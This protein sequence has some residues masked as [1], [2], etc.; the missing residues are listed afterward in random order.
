MKEE[1]FINWLDK[2]LFSVAVSKGLLSHPI[3]CISLLLGVYLS[4]DIGLVPTSSSTIA[5]ST[6]SSASSSTIL[7]SPIGIVVFN[8]GDV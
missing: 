3:L 8:L 1:S 5:L 2:N 7:D 6:L 4:E